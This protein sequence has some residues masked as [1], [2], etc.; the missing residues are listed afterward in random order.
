LFYGLLAIWIVYVLNLFEENIPYIIGP[1]LYSVIVY[2]ITYLA[3]SKKLLQNINA[4]KYQSTSFAGEEIDTL[5]NNVER[6]MQNEKLFLDPGV[7]LSMLSK[8][9]RV[10]PQKISFAIN[11]KSQ[12]NFNEYINRYRVNHAVTLMQMPGA[13]SVTIASIATDSGFNSLSSFNNSFKKAFGKTPSAF[14]RSGTD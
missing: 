5:F 13:D 10:S 2:A 1:I 3:I 8:Q 4:V 11:S 12:Y 14:R 7:S 6:I 9:L